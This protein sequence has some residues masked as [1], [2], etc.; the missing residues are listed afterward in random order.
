[1]SKREKEIGALPLSE[2]FD[3]VYEQRMWQQ[4]SA[5]SGVGSEGPWAERYVTLVREYLAEHKPT[6][7][8]DAGCGDFSV[9]RLLCDLPPRYVAADV[10]AYITSLNRERYS[11]LT[12]V[13][14]LQLDLTSDDLPAADVVLVRQ[15]LQHLTNQQIEAALSNLERQLPASRVIIAEEV[16]TG[17]AFARPNI[18]LPS[19]SVRTRTWFGSGVFPSEP[20]FLRPMR[21][22]ATI[23]GTDDKSSMNIYEWPPAGHSN[24]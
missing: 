8:L 11:H 20:P 10:S 2:A 21:L 5:L 23:A 24:D 16:A 13:E 17:S 12:Q 18:D 1:M 22:L 15:V 7:V 3:R 19:Q 4:G 9:G 14:F 6:C